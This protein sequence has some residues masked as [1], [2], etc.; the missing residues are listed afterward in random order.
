MQH[1]GRSKQIHSLKAR[2]AE[3]ANHHN[4]TREEIKAAQLACERAQRAFEQTRAALERSRDVL[5]QSFK[6]L[7]PISVQGQNR[8]QE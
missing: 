4:V 3:E 5:E 8:A 1:L 2:L 6:V 7:G